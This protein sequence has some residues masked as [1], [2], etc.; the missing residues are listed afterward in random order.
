MSTIVPDLVPVRALNQVS[1]CPRLY[2]LEYVESVMPTNEY[3]EDGL[4]QHRRVNN[5]DLENRTRKQGE[6]LHTRSVSLSSERLGITGKLDLMEERGGVAR[7]IEYKRSA[8]PTG[9]D[10]RP[11][12]YE[13]D[14]IQ[15]CAQGL[16]LE[17]EF[18]APVPEGVLYYIG[19]KTRVDVPLDRELRN[20]TVAAIATIGFLS[21]RDTPPEP[22]PDELRHRC[23][24]CSLATICLPEET[25]YAIHH[26]EPAP[27]PAA[28]TV[29]RV[30]A[31]NDDGA[32]L[33]LHEQGAHIGKR[34][35]HLVVHLHGQ[36]I[37]R[38]P[39]ASVRQVVVFG[40]VQV[41]TQALACLA[42]SEVPVVYLTSYGRF[43]AALM[44]AP[45]KNVSLR[46]KQHRIFADPAHAL[47][48]AKEVVRAK[49]TNQRTLLM[50]SLRSRSSAAD[51]PESTEPS[52][53]SDE[54]A[55]RDMAELLTRIDRVAEPGSLLGIEGQA[56]SLYFGQFGRMLR[57]PGPDR[58][59]DFRNRNRRPPRDPANALL[60]FAYAIL[61]KDCFSALCTVGFDPYLGFYHAGRHGRPSLA[62]DIMEEFRSVIADS[63]VLTLVNNGLVTA[64][65][66]L[67]WR[68]ACQLTADGRKRFFETY[69]Q[70]KATVVTHPT[71]GYKMSYGRMLEVQAR[72][73]AA[74]IRGDIPS[75][76]GFTVR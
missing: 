19:S 31:Q 42:S 72:M 9:D 7:P 46:A 49:I 17:E 20:K 5:P 71:Y 33:Y 1:Y 62:L 35:E 69:E 34:S 26:P 30:V 61:A 52:R 56:A 44:P 53:G 36:Q 15:L 57:S 38:V 13:N 75:Y 40:N 64:R 45:A 70:R 22:L 68:D 60:S 32:V 47:A 51:A 16:L 76:T 6:A 18:G 50:R 41:S 29:T 66:F 43:V 65:D 28:G 4:F 11:T 12:A 59:F 25:L 2:Y 73:L 8:A 67:I 54:P 37:N 21:A 55:A 39:I 3:V 24:G 23:H 48:L 74:F 63:V 27:E 14:A 10:G 58:P